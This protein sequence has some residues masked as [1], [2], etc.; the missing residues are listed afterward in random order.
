MQCNYAYWVTYTGKLVIQY[1]RKYIFVNLIDN[2][3]E[4][5]NGYQ[6]SI[7]GWLKVATPKNKDQQQRHVR[8]QL[9]NGA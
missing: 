4:F 9:K 1:I 3:Y 5:D 6:N 2:Q 8:G 7:N